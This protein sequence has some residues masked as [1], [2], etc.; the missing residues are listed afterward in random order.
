[1]SEFA[2]PARNRPTAV[3]VLGILHIVFGS[4]YLLL[5]TCGGLLLLA[6]ADKMTPKDQTELQARAQ[7]HLRQEYPLLTALGPALQVLNVALAAVLVVAGA[8]LLNMRPWARRASLGYAFTH[9]AVLAWTLVT[10]VLYT[11]PALN[12]FLEDE[13]A[14]NPKAASL[15][16]LMRAGMPVGIG[17]NAVLM[18]YPVVVLVTLLR[19]S[20]RAAFAAPEGSD[21]T[22]DPPRA[23]GDGPPEGSFTR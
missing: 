19:P 15:A 7:E 1:M 18:A 11:L 5:A 3:L 12:A 10:S 8:G 21:A 6:G 16:S 23:W 17:V 20:V 9:L 4:L 22:P 14:R 13:A 2:Y